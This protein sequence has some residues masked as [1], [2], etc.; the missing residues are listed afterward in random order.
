VISKIPGPGIDKLAVTVATT[1]KKALPIGRA[2]FVIVTH[3][4]LQDSPWHHQQRSECLN[5]PSIISLD[6]HGKANE[7]FPPDHLNVDRPVKP[8]LALPV[9][10]DRCCLRTRRVPLCKLFPH[11]LSTGEKNE[12]GEGVLRAPFLRCGR[13]SGR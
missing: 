1:D 2:F 10:A 4:P 6:E 12:A 5:R 9:I 13:K 11:C 7:R 8:V 3:N